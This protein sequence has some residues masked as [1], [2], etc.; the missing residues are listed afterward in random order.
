LIYEKA[1]DGIQTFDDRILNAASNDLLAIFINAFISG[2]VA[3]ATRAGYLRFLAAGQSGG[4]AR[5][6][7]HRQSKS[8]H[9]GAVQPPRET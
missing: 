6:N 8:S 1:D 7:P 5:V 4:Y 2:L 3:G 9:R